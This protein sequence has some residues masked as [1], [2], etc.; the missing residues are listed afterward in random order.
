MLLE[1]LALLVVL[2]VT[3]RQAG[4]GLGAQYLD[5][6]KITWLPEAV[7]ALCLGWV[8][9]QSWSFPHQFGYPFVFAVSSLWSYIWMQTGHGTAFHMGLNPK[10][11]QGT[12]KQTLSAVVDPICKK[13]GW[14]L[15]EFNYCFLFMG[16]KGLLTALP[17][18]PL[19]LLNFLAWPMAY[20]IGRYRFNSGAACELTSGFFIAILA[21]L[22]LVLFGM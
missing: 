11:A 17:L 1:I 7:F 3:A 12:R 14:T 5:R 8:A 21:S 2:T 4:G 6:F 22:T 10:E 16:I 15:G 9:A 19:A 18:G 13:L 20:I